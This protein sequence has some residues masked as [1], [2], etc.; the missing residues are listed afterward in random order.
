MIIIFTVVYI[1]FFETLD[2]VKKDLDLILGWKSY[3]PTS[4][5]QG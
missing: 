2:K 4:L 5:C 3:L 1:G